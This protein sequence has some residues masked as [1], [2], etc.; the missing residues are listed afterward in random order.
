MDPILKLTFKY[1]FEDF[2]AQQQQNFQKYRY[3]K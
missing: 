3:E 2:T 1:S